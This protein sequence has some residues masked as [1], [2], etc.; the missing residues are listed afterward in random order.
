MKSQFLRQRQVTESESDCGRDSVSTRVRFVWAATT[1]V[2]IGTFVFF[3]ADESGQA[4]ADF[5]DALIT[6]VGPGV[7]DHTPVRL[8]PDGGSRRFGAAEVSFPG[9]EIP[10]ANDLVFGLANSSGSDSLELIRGP[11][12]PLGGTAI[13][14][15]WNAP[16]MES[17]E[18]DNL[19]GILHNPQGNLLGVNFGTPESGGSI[20]SLATSSPVP[21]AQ[22]I[23]N[24][25]GLG[26]GGLTLSRLGALSVSPDNRKVAVS[27][28]DSARV[29]VFDYTAGD[30]MGSGASLSGARE[31]EP[32]LCASNDTQGTTWVNNDVVLAF[33]ST[34]EILAVDAT[35]MASDVVAFVD[36]GLPAPCGQGFTDLEFN[37]Q[38]IRRVFAM[39]GGF[40]DGA[41]KNTLA[42][43][44]GMEDGLGILG[45]FDFSLSMDT[46]REI[47]LGSR[48]NLYVG[49]FGGAIDII[50]DVNDLDSMTDNNSF[51]WY[52][53][54]TSAP[55]SGLDVALEMPEQI[56]GPGCVPGALDLYDF[57][58]SGDVALTD[59]AALATCAS[60]P[61]QMPDP[62]PPSSPADCLATF[63]SDDDGDVDLADG[64]GFFSHFTGPCTGLGECPEG[65]HLEHSSGVAG[66]FDPDTFDPQTADAG[67]YRCVEDETCDGITCSERG[68]CTVLS[69]AA[70]CACEPGYGGQACDECTTA[71]ERDQDSGTCI[72]GPECRERYCSGQG[73]CQIQEGGD[74]L[75]V[76]DPGAEGE[77]CEHGGGDPTILR[78]P[79]YVVIEGTDESLGQGEQRLICPTFFGGGLLALDM[80][81][82]LDGP[83]ELLPGPGQCQLY[84]APPP[85]SFSDAQVAGLTVCPLEFPEECATRYITID[86]PG[87]IKSNGQTNLLF[88]PFDDAV[89]Q[90][91]RHRC[92]GAAVLGVSV[93]GK[94]VYVRGYGNLSG[95]PTSDPDYLAECGDTF[96]VSDAVP[97][98][99]LPDPSQ[100]Q[101][102]TPFRIGSI[103]KSVTAAILRKAVKEAF[104]EVDTDDEVEARRL[105]DGLLPPA[106]HDV[107]CGGHPPPVPL[108]SDDPDDPTY[109]DSLG[110]HADDRWDDMT[111]GH[112]LSH[113]S[114][115]P[116]KNPDRNTVILP[117]LWRLRHLMVESDWADEEDA[118]TSETGFPAGDFSAEFPDFS[119]AK[120]EIGSSAYFVR[121]SLPGETT[122]TQLGACLNATPGTKYVY[123]NAG[124]GL[125]G[126]ISEAISSR[127]Y[128]ARDGKPGL[129]SGSL[130]EDFAQHQLGLPIPGQQTAEGIYVRQGAF[131]LR[132]PAEPIWRHWSA[133][134]GTYY[135]LARPK[136]RPY[137]DWDSSSGLCRFTDWLGGV[138]RFDWTFAE[139]KAI[140]TGYR[141]A[142]R[143]AGGLATETEVFLRFMAK[144]WVGGSGSNPR[145]GESR[146][147]GGDCIWT[148]ATNHNG[149]A[150]GARAEAWQLGGTPLLK[151]DGSTVDC[152]VDGDC[153]YTA[154][155]GT[156]QAE[157]VQGFCLGPVGEKRCHKRNQYKIPPIDPE[158]RQITDDFADLE[159]HFCRLPVGVDIFVAIN[160][161]RD[162][163]CTEAEAL[164]ED[165]PDYYTCGEAYGELINFVLHAACQVPWPASQF[166]LW[167]PVIE[168]GSSMSPAFEA[169]G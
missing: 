124:F 156:D 58:Q 109:C 8:S 40:S 101:P 32:I 49:Q 51:D 69:G 62:E 38:I 166:V 59:Y 133:S 64:A 127:E 77:Y 11:A 154:C 161:R 85:G 130:L 125:L 24:T 126:L 46:A 98:Y 3:A 139:K 42:V 129:H 19:D 80:V 45:A 100:V 63:D 66:V 89:K 48:G 68:V 158:T 35:T 106:L 147:P 102:N 157:D 167:P 1:L 155:K 151:R 26:G 18:F 114:G 163:K 96:D 15:A 118:L 145:Y 5:D 162:K 150:N 160:Q 50:P 81:W 9:V 132:N 54:S 95:A 116:R 138:D 115:L 146:C 105:C 143:T 22:L 110:T 65:T 97:G 12:L 76:C 104:S 142:G 99:T 93:F 27:G 44:W 94:P 74:I 67:E 111:L 34:G 90:F 120:G 112:L 86:P 140:D 152:E 70:A 60:G 122:L 10:Q 75:C 71:Y 169:G 103:T 56:E 78:A 16:F 30:T 84:N 128:G 41:T 17:V 92:V 88:K 2:V 121:G 13:P 87:G 31:S 37:P 4:I 52:T 6:A 39:Y 135:P 61:E 164:D 168:G 79:T 107:A 159:C 47:A 23:G 131:H 20:W 83:G 136:R 43:L 21:D 149:S 82:T 117:N 55:F 72:L 57:D 29:I 134:A 153:T 91:M 119:D 28:L 25:T 148:K 33:S 7:A 36:V 108:P 144:Y 137:C 53:S 73:D 113:R 165:D 141:G 14:D 123:S